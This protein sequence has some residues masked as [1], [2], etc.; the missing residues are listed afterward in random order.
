MASTWILNKFKDEH[1][2]GI[3]VDKHDY[4]NIKDPRK[5]RCYAVGTKNHKSGTWDVWSIPELDMQILPLWYLTKL[6]IEAE[7]AEKNGAPSTGPAQTKPK[8]PIIPLFDKNG[9]GKVNEEDEK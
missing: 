9:D 5:W 1:Y 7:E 3:F 8:I 4:D 2:V 6:Q